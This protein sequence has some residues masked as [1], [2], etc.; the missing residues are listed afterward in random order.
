MQI[1]KK[2]K[3][4]LSAKSNYHFTMLGESGFGNFTFDPREIKT[5]YLSFGYQ[6]W[7]PEKKRIF[8]LRLVILVFETNIG[9]KV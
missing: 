3:L 8:I 2:L 7:P 4:W 9:I 6:Y 5:P 1:I